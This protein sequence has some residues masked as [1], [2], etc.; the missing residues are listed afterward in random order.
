MAARRRG[1]ATKNKSVASKMHPHSASF[2]LRRELKLLRCP[3]HIVERLCRYGYD[4]RGSFAAF[5]DHISPTLS[6]NVAP[7]IGHSALRLEVMGT[8]AQEREATQAE[9]E[10]MAAL[11]EEAMA[12]CCSS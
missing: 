8:E 2:D 12:S 11:V 6:I 5:L 10:A 7:L 4:D 3:P 9:I 1:K